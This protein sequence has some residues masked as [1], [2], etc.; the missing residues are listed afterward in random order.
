M[1][2]KRGDEEVDL[3]GKT[4]KPMD[5]VELDQLLASQGGIRPPTIYGRNVERC[6][7]EYM[8]ENGQADQA[9]V[10]ATQCRFS[11][12]SERAAKIIVAN[13]DGVYMRRCVVR[14]KVRPHTSR[15]VRSQKEDV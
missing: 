7:V 9:L 2:Q 12:L 14:A 10:L 6:D 15:R 1:A 3:P 5:L 4:K 13:S 11:D 8:I